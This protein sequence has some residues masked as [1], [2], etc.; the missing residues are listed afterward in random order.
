MK[1]SV[2]DEKGVKKIVPIP[3][4]QQTVNTLFGTDIHS[5]EE[6]EDWLS[7]RR[8]NLEGKKPSNGEEMSLSR[9]GTDL[10]EKVNK[11]KTKNFFVC[12]LNTITTCESLKILFDFSF[13]IFK[14][15]TKK[16][17]DKYP[18]ELDASV[19]ARLP[20]RVNNESRYFNDPYEALPKHGYTRFFENILLQDKNIDVRLN[21]D[22]FKV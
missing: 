9:V 2:S 6:M 1:G 21:V 4:N 11:Y 18:D 16:Q 14:H 19:L 12:F 10:Y 13:Q 17:W 22:Y 20:F 5:E 8:P 3:P 15:Y 7:S